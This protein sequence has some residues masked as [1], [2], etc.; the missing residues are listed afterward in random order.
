M[1]KF[2]FII[3]VPANTEAEA[4]AKL[5]LLMEL[6]AFFK[7]FDP[8]HLTRSVIIYLLHYYAGKYCPDPNS[9]KKQ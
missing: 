9:S 8:T 4:Q 6:G 7:E 3:E 1:E 5:N 2:R